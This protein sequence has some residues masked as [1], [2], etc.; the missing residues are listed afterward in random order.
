MRSVRLFFE[1]V[2]FEHTIFALPFA[3]MGALLAGRGEVTLWEWFWITMAMVGARTAGM[4]L[5]RLVDR[6]IDA[7]NP[8]TRERTLPRGAMSAASVRWLILGSIALLELAAFQ[9][10][11][12]CVW[13]SPLAVALLAIYSYL[14]RYTPYAHA[15]V[16]LVL[17]C[18]PVGAWT[19]VRGTLDWPV[20]LLG[21][22]VLCWVAGFDI[23]Y[24]CQDIDFDRREGLHSIPQALGAA[25]ALTIARRLH[26]ATFALLVAMAVV[27]H[28]G[29][30]FYGGVGVI[31]ALL[32]YEHGLVSERDLSRINQAFFNVNGYISVTLYLATLAH[33]RL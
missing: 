3:Y 12:I 33:Y 22:A 16:G 8:R 5:N 26:V 19:A 15:G 13:L 1:L 30:W 28:L 20:L 24:A 14:K 25:R 23:L 4:S 7:R 17:A 2:K 27:L 18:A 21:A 29:P 32:V 10:Q 31:G 6:D 11:P 9:L